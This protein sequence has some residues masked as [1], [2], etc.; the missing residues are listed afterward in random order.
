MKRNESPLDRL[1]RKQHRQK[2]QQ[3]GKGHRAPPPQILPPPS[4]PMR[5]A[6]QFVR[7]Y[8]LQDGVP[9]LRYW[10]DGWWAWRT[11]RWV[12]I[13]RV[14]VRELLY[15]FTEHAI[16]LTDS[17]ANP[18]SPTRHKVS[19]LVDA[20]GAII[21]LAD[22]FN[23][24]AWLDGRST[25]TIVAVGNGLLELESRRLLSHTPQFFNQTAVPFDYDAGAPNPTY[26]HTFLNTL[27]WPQ[28][29]DLSEEAKAE[30]HTEAQNAIRVLGEWFG[31]VISGRM[32]LHKI[33]LMVGPTR[34]GKGAI[35]RVLTAL[36][37][38][39][40]VAGPTLNS[41][42]GD[43]GLAPLIGKPLAIISDARFVGKNGSIVVERLL[44]ISGEDTL[45]VNR[46]YR[47]QWTGK[48]PSRLHVIS[49]ELPKLGDASTAIVGRIILLPLS[50]SWL[51]KEDHELEAR[52][53]AELPG[54]LNWA[55]DGLA[56]LTVENGNRFTRLASAEE[57]IVA[58]RDL[59]SPIAAFVRE[60]C[61]LDSA[62]VIAV[63][64]LYNSFK[65][66]ADD[67]G[68]IKPSK[69]VFGR[70]LRAAVPSI[71]IGQSGPHSSR[72]RVYRGIRLKADK[73]REAEQEREPD[74]DLR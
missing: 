42:G 34:G 63:D 35:A 54:I 45:T 27:W 28:I 38:K 73:E 70:D 15:R 71:R 44:S 66:W 49:N 62:G 8:C 40:N 9:I 47:E 64:K 58:M 3:G 37:G 21:F 53:H 24:P 69:Q 36:V 57:A 2:Q 52:L 20:L 4:D 31:Y 65:F 16:Y 17:G 19:D 43:F 41:L 51:G 11:S 33:L 30:L 74:L 39:D 29:E 26:W 22:E 67:N 10:R 59:A 5:V 12:E 14:A 48:L 7:E 32:D 56:R 6:R 68:H 60:K 46:K 13:S 61:T 18:W 23:Q 1:A 72:E 25:G 55:L 50:R